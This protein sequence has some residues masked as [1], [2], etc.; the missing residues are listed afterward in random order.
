MLDQAK[1]AEVE[2]EFYEHLE[3]LMTPDAE[4]I[5]QLTEVA[6]EHAKDGYAQQVVAAVEERIGTAPRSANLA[7]WYA[8]DSIVK[9]AG[10]E[11]RVLFARNL[12]RLVK[13]RMEP[14]INEANQGDYALLLDCWVTQRIFPNSILAELHQSSDSGSRPSTTTPKPRT[15]TTTTTTTTTRPSGPPHTM[16]LAATSSSSS[17]SGAPVAPIPSVGVPHCR[18]WFMQSLTWSRTKEHNWTHCVQATSDAIAKS[19][20]R[21]G[22]GPEPTSPKSPGTPRRLYP[23]VP[24]PGNEK[25]QCA[26]CKDIMTPYVIDNG[27]YALPDSVLIKVTPFQVGHAACCD[28][29]G[30][31]A[32]DPRQLQNTQNTPK[33][34]PALNALLQ[35][36]A[37]KPTPVKQPVT[38]SSVV[39]PFPKRPKLE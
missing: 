32:V 4:D 26:Y 14:F 35:K 16:P 3:D 21:K 6:K 2:S 38:N 22:N 34:S 9:L 7:A 31:T 39:G 13:S 37:V 10:E 36:V 1:A 30:V 24:V 27:T 20:E 11:Y 19:R 23:D 8:M 25:H 15:A 17:S 12:V 33:L 29:A 18:A 28:I 5:H